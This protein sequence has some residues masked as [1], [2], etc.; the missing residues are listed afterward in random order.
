MRK[1]IAGELR[2]PVDADIIREVKKG[3]V[4]NTADST[5]CFAYHPY[6]VEASESLEMLLSIWHRR[7]TIH[8]LAIE[9][10]STK[11]KKGQQRMAL[12]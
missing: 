4:R 1:V 6:M 3:A 12:H 11:G 2:G 10:F 5:P 8:Q 7:Q 9:S